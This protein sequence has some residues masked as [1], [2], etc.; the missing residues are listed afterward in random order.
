M[1]RMGGI[2]IKLHGRFSVVPVI[3]I[4]IGYAELCGWLER[5]AP[6]QWSEFVRAYGN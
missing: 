2:D 1:N 5:Y 6:A 3:S 4:D